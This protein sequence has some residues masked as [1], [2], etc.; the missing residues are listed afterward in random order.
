MSCDI[1]IGRAL[2]CKTSVGGIKNIYFVPFGSMGTVTLDNWNRIQAVTG[3]PYAFKFEVLRDADLD[4]R[5]QSSAVNGT[6]FV[7]QT[8]KATLKQLDFA[9]DN[10]IMKLSYSRPHI[11]VEDLNG[12]YFMIGYKNGVDMRTSNVKTGRAMGDLSGYELTFTGEEKLLANYLVGTPLDLGF[13]VVDDSYEYFVDLF[14]A[15]VLG[16]GG[17]VEATDCA[18]EDLADLATE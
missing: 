13:D 14:I 5:I 17:S 18:L 12:N 1:S 15:R 2:R 9:T 11:I 3:S 8:L 10:A 7:E 4:Q 6:T 16:D